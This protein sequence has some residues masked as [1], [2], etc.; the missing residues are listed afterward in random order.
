MIKK[1]KVF[2]L[3]MIAGANIAS[4][5]F[6]LAVGYSDRINPASFPVLSTVGLTFPVF[7]L[8]NFGF[9]VF[10]LL[11]KKRGAIIPLVGFL[12]CYIPIRKYCPLNISHE[13]PAG[14]IKVLSYNVWY[15]AG[16][17][18]KDGKVNPILDYI[19][20]QDADIVCLQESATNEVGKQKV[21]SILNPIYQYRDT[22]RHGAGDVISIFSKYPILSKEH[23]DYKSRGNISAAFKLIVDGTEVLVI[24][25]HLETTALTPDDKSRFSSMIKGDMKANSAESTSKLLI[26]KLAKATAIRGPQAEAVARYMAYHRNLPIILCGDFNDGPISYAHRTVAKDLTDCYIESGNGPGISYHHNRFYVRID[27]IMCSSDFK[28]YGCH[29]DN[30]IKTSDHYPIICWLKKRPKTAK[31][32]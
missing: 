26:K 18:D 17:E 16:W 31:N 2:T 20:K 32:E 5:L 14:S 21:D 28:P 12:I 6:M 10:W 4:I 23:I 9:L 1:L 13:P 25:N 19:R 15:F 8:I 22:A 3:Q 29:V 30:S 24:N 7:L 11:F 27:N